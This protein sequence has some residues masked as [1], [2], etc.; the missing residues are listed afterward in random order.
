MRSFYRFHI[1]DPIFFSKD[2]RITM[3]QIGMSNEWHFERQDDISTVAYWYQGE[4][5]APFPELPDRKYR[6]PR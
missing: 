6:E 4:P 2:L 3:Q 5:H 1:L